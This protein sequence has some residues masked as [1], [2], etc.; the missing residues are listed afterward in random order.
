M[1][2]GV[3]ECSGIHGS[4]FATLL[5]DDNVR[6]SCAYHNSKLRACAIDWNGINLV[7]VG[8][9]LG[10]ECLALCYRKLMVWLKTDLEFVACSVS[11]TVS[12]E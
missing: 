9:W 11:H 8:D 2:A 12:P 5:F 1:G 7:I 6:L 10:L 4:H 3:Q